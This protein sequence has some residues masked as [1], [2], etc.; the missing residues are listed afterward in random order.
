MDPNQEYVGRDDGGST[1]PIG[2]NSVLSLD[3]SK[4]YIDIGAKKY[5]VTGPPRYHM[6][7]IMAGRK[8]RLA[9]QPVDI[10]GDAYRWIDVSLS[11]SSFNGTFTHMI[12]DGVAEVTSLSGMIRILNEQSS[13]CPARSP[14]RSPTRPRWWGSSRLNVITITV[15]YEAFVPKILSWKCLAFVHGQLKRSRNASPYIPSQHQH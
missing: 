15:F 3:P 7:V 4:Y 8:G 13:M 11:V 12:A 6:D 2:K 9:G 10:G 1:L 5:Y 14:H